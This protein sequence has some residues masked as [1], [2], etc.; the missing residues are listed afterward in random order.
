[1]EALPKKYILDKFQEH[2]QTNFESFCE[3]HDIE[4]TPS[5]CVNFMIDQGLIAPAHLQRY[6]VARE[7]EKI[8]AEYNYPKTQVVGT[9]ANRFS[10][11]ERTVWSVLRH[12][13]PGQK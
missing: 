8:C 6:A 4:K 2:L 9:L 7:F 5:Q 11:S 12:N 13:K 10:L 3:R 1:M